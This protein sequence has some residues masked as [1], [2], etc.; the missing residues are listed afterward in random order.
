MAEQKLNGLNELDEFRL[1]AHESSVIYKEKMKKYHNKRIGKLEFA[2]CD[3]MVLLNSRL[4][5]FPGKIKSKWTGP[6]LIT[7]VLSHKAVNFEN[8]EGG[9]FR[10]NGQRIKI[11]LRH[12]ASVLEVV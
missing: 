12:A 2:V 3:L 4:H 6:F 10:V 9:K 7:K 1:R 5:L 11:Y 8:K